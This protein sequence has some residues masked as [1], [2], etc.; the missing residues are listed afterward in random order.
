VH[1]LGQPDPGAA[2][3]RAA[4]HHRWLQSGLANPKRRLLIATTADGCPMGQIR[5]DRQSA[6]TEGSAC[7]AMVALS[8]ADPARPLR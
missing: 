8:L 6:S 3:N 2:R 1:I 5:F 4:D 7:Q